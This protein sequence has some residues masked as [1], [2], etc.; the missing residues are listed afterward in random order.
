[1]VISQLGA[2]LVIGILS[3]PMFAACVNGESGILTEDEPVVMDYYAEKMKIDEDVDRR[4]I[5]TEAIY[6]NI[7]VK[8][9]GTSSMSSEMSDILCGSTSKISFLSTKQEYSEIKEGQD[10]IIIDGFWLNGV[11]KKDVKEELTPIMQKGVPIVVVGRNLDLISMIADEIYPGLFYEPTSFAAGFRYYPMEKSTHIFAAGDETT[12][13]EN[14]RSVLRSLYIWAD[15]ELSNSMCHTIEE[16]AASVAEY[17]ASEEVQSVMMP[18]STTPYWDLNPNEYYWFEAD[19]FWPK[20]R[21]LIH[22]YYRQLL[23]DTDPQNGNHYIVQYRWV[24]T[25]GER[26]AIQGIT[27]SQ[28]QP[29]V[30]YH[31]DWLQLENDLN[32]DSVWHPNDHMDIDSSGNMYVPGTMVGP[33]TQSVSIGIGV[34]GVTYGHQY[35]VNIPYPQVWWQGIESEQLAKWWYN[36]DENSDYSTVEFAANPSLN[37]HCPGAQG[38]SNGGYYDN[39]PVWKISWNYM[40]YEQSSKQFWAVGWPKP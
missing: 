15:H 14:L 22:N 11:S 10:L 23:D 33:S 8:I 1:M 38:T 6:T 37:A 28:G 2:F 5:N 31:L 40:F 29:Y 30:S 25:P 26:L 20:G 12:T 21:G 27:N 18:Q 32:T 24:A 16:A 39:G 36:I 3:V 35:S 9:I 4:I 34:S 13:T 7:S 19:A 17:S